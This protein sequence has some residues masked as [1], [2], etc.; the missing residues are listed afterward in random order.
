MKVH[1][2]EITEEQINAGKSAMIGE[3]TKSEVAQRMVRA[4]V[5]VLSGSGW[6]TEHV[7]ERAVDRL[8]QRQRKSGAIKAV[9]NR[10]WKA[11]EP[12]PSQ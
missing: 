2:I 11:Y 10:I 9:T 8:L 5:P 4:G 1:G 3:F 12:S 6:R 7:L